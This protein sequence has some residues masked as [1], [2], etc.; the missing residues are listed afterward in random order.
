VPQLEPYLD[1][2]RVSVVPLL[3]GAGVKRKIVQS[4]IN[5]T[6]VL[7][8][9]IGAEGLDIRHDEHALIAD[10]PSELAAGLTRLL[11]NRDDWQRIA[12]AGYEHAYGRHDP[13]ILGRR[14]HEIIDEVLGLPAREEPAGTGLGRMQ[15]TQVAYRDTVAAV[16]A[17]L[18]SI[19]DPGSTVLVV[20]RGDD[21]L[22]GVEGRNARH[23]PESPDGNWAGYHPADS[24]AAIRHLEALRERGARYFALPSTSF[25]WLHHYR[26]LAEHLESNYRRIHSDEHLVL[27]DVGEETSHAVERPAGDRERVLVIGTYK[28]GRAG[29]PPSLVADLERSDRYRVSQE[30]RAGDDPL[31]EADSGRDGADWTVFVSDEAVVP[32]GFLDDFLTAASQLA[33]LGV[34]RIQPPHAN[35][36]DGGPPVTERLGGVLAREVEAV[37]PLPLLAV[38]GEAPTEGPVALLDAVPITLGVPLGFDPDASSFSNV[39]DVFVAKEDGAA[40]AVRRSQGSPAPLISVVIATYERPELLAECLERFSEQTLQVA[41]YEIV[42]IDDGSGDDAVAGV[43]S[44]MESRLPLTWVRIEHAG[45]SAAKNLGVLL[46][47]GE[48]ILFFDDDDWPSPELLNEHVSAHQAHPSEEIAILGRTDWAPDLSIT[49]LMRHVTEVDRLLFSYDSF[50]PGERIDWRGFWEGRVSSKRSLHLR[51]GLHDQRLDYSIDIEMAWRLARYGLQVIYEPKALSFMARA[52][53][54]EAFCQRHEAKGRAAAAISALHDDPEI[55]EYTQVDGASERWD[56]A[57]PGYGALV[58]RIARL[59]NELGPSGGSDD[60]P[61]GTELH[62]AYRAALRACNVKGIAEALQGAAPSPRPSARERTNGRRRT[63]PPL[64]RESARPKAVA[65]GDGNG[66][67]D[68]EAP[69]LTVTMPVWS[70][71]PELAE[72]AIRTIDRMW[73]VARLPTEMVVIDNGSP[74][75]RQMRARVHRFEENRGVATAWNTGIELARAPV[76]AVLNSDCMVDPGWDEALY[77]AVTT[78]RRIAFPYTDHC[79]GLGYRRPDQAGTAGW[80]FMLTR[81]TFDEVGPFDERFNPAYVEDTDYWHRAWELGIELTPVPDARVVH[82]RRTSSDDHSDWLLKGHRYLYGWK[83]GV[84]PMRAPPYYNREIVEYERQGEGSRAST[85]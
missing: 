19:T 65:V 60:D 45:R 37:T 73:E 36:P 72:M 28:P 85:T 21:K 15:R 11:T 56:E 30:W 5:G 82:A 22:A 47:R 59:E 80:C 51:R 17:T 34:D 43:L 10:G 42:V 35:G 57:R 81:E 75:Q 67:D 55:R 31:A 38:R 3:H 53:D 24:E 66:H 62:E 69:T 16:N 77:E 63:P 6:P 64:R 70:R 41:D 27:F 46:A 54:F 33:P 1:Q 23:F 40:R 2:T 76:V 44:E 71:T 9:P 79:D 18:R 4:L 78:G 61:R 52:V 49:P 8:T 39:R 12:D 74:E 50:E 29:P 20:S 32:A 13:E 68:S 7:T 58:S 84:E 26:E 83:H 48:L 25:W 14:F